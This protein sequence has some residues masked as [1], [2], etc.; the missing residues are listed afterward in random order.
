MFVIL[1][2]NSTSQRALLQ[3][4]NRVRSLKDNNVSV[5]L[6]GLKFREKIN[7]YTFNEAKFMFDKYH[8]SDANID[9]DIEGNL[10][11]R[12]NNNYYNLC[13]YNYLEELNKQRCYFVPYLIKL[14]N[15]KKYTY[16]FDNTK[17]KIN[18]ND[19]NILLEEI[20]EAEDITKNTY[21]HLLKKQRNNQATRNEKI[22]IERFL[23]K[24]KW[25]IDVI[26]R[27][28]LEKA[29]RKMH[30]LDNYISIG[31]II[32]DKRLKPPEI[33]PTNTEENTDEIIENE[34]MK[35]KEEDIDEI[36]EDEDI[37]EI[38]EDEEIKGEILK[39]DKFNDV[40]KNKKIEAITKIIILLGYTNVND[41]S[42][43]EKDIFIQN[44]EKV[45]KESILFNDKNMATLFKL[46]KKQFTQTKSFLNIIN[47]IFSDYG[48]NIKLKKYGGVKTRKYSYYINVI[49]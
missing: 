43:I 3:M 23:Y 30:V 47:S 7:F 29:Y 28:F 4:C 2:D 13:I 41:K 36:I 25:K 39:E 12:K 22:I 17:I 34:E 33:K 8:L 42:F 20:L 9:S 49:I 45:K 1:C 27:E 40:L 26:N 46:H 31:G 32:E 10:I 37:D 48:F 5:F 19:S 44:I 15:E 18:K 11:T 24:T 21:L 14:L 35:G 6:N 38:I 16:E